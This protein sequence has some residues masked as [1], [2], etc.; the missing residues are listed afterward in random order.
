MLFPS[1][2]QV[3]ACSSL[4]IS[5]FS[6]SACMNPGQ[7][8]APPLPALTEAAPFSVADT[9]L[10]AKINDVDLTHIALASLAKT[11]AARNDIAQ[12]GETIAKDLTDNHD[13][14]TA[15]ATTGKATLVAK[16][17]AQNQKLI[18]QM[19]H[20]HGSAFDRAYARYLASSAK[21]TSAAIDAGNSAST[22]ADLAKLAVD[23]KTKLL[24]Y[25][26]QAK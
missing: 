18:S 9:N 8:P 15:L 10:A 24:G 23:L 22:N 5:L 13:K 1:R 14:L 17:S 21:T 25:E 4:I 19:Q 16:P 2:H 26:A 20:L 7:P 6:L 3:L 12:L 11:N